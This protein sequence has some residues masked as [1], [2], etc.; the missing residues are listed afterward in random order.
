MI[1]PSNF[2]MESRTPK[3][4]TSSGRLRLLMIT[5]LLILFV[6]LTAS[7]GWIYFDS[8]EGDNP[9]GTAPLTETTSVS[10]NQLL[11]QQA[12]LSDKAGRLEQANATIAALTSTV[13]SLTVQLQ[14]AIA[15]QTTQ[16]NTIDLLAASI[17]SFKTTYQQDQ[18]QLHQ[19]QAELMCDNAGYF[20][21]DYSS[22]ASLSNSLKAFIGQIGGNTTY[23]TWDLLWPNSKNATHRITVHQDGRSFTN[24]F[25]VYF[26]EKDFSNKGV[27]WV[28]RGCWLDK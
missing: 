28:N 22:N 5:A 16:I 3:I 19:I 24:V 13:N 2:D 9:L 23:A 20:K 4:P 7:L 25:I 11:Q 18:D 15:T 10:Q 12:E 27:F 17:E 14:S 21:A 8:L 1:E 6:G 26:N